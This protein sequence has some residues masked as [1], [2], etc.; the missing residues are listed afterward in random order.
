MT[1]FYLPCLLSVI[2][3]FLSVMFL[4]DSYN[5]FFFPPVLVFFLQVF[6]QH[7]AVN[8]CTT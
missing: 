2:T 8:K 7:K 1:L 4:S 5:L 3:Y 6:M